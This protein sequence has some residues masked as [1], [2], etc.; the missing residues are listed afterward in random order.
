MENNQGK[1]W[2]VFLQFKPGA[3]F[4]HVGSVHAFE[5]E[6]AIQNARDLYS[7]RKE[8]SNIWVVDSKNIVSTSPGD[9]A[10]FFD[11]ADDKIYRHPTFYEVPDGAK[12]M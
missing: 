6:M 5:A 11:P 7:R 3:A 10:S 8:A 1:L 9:Q 2:E 4:K 12:H